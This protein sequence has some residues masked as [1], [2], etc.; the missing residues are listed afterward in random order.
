MGKPKVLSSGLRE[1]LWN[2]KELSLEEKAVLIAL[3]LITDGNG[4]VTHYESLQQG[5]SVPLTVNGAA[6]LLGGNSRRKKVARLIKNLT[7]KGYLVQVPARY[8]YDLRLTDQAL[9]ALGAF[10]L[11]DS[12]VVDLGRV[13][14]AARP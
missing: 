1:M 3:T 12:K 4:T 5:F 14:L 8:G 7:E 6:T 9:A 11:P 13:R 10:R 2:N